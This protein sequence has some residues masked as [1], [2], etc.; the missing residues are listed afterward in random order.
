MVTSQPTLLSPTVQ[1]EPSSIE[2]ISQTRPQ[3]GTST[4]SRSGFPQSQPLPVDPFQAASIDCGEDCFVGSFVIRVPEPSISS[5]FGPPQP[6]SLQGVGGLMGTLLLPANVAAGSLMN[7]S[8]IQTKNAFSANVDSGSFQLGSTLLD[9]NMFGPTGESVDKF[10]DSIR[11]CISEPLG[12]LPPGSCLGFYNTTSYSWECQD[13]EL[14]LEGNNTFCGDTGKAQPSNS[15]SQG[16]I[17]LL[18]RSFDFVCSAPWR[19]TSI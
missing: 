3:V 7:A 4:P 8:W 2:T 13:R 19:T 18:Y 5:S 14:R 11:I 1:V 15:S 6:L 16:T 9:I 17:S 12:F 10:K